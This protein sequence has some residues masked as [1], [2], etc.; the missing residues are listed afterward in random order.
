MLNVAGEDVLKARKLGEESGPPTHDVVRLPDQLAGLIGDVFGARCVAW[1][2]DLS[3]EPG[4]RRLAVLLVPI[5]PF[6][7]SR[8]RARAT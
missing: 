4:R 6:H 3:A 1:L 2:C 8:V 5:H 7:P